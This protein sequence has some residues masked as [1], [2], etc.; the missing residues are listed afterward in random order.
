MPSDGPTPPRSSIR[1]IHAPSARRS[2]C[3]E[4]ALARN[5]RRRIGR[6]ARRCAQ[7][8]PRRARARPSTPRPR[9]RC[10]RF[11]TPHFEG[12][13]RTQFTRDLS[14]KD[15]VLHV[16]RG[17]RLVGFSTLPIFHTAFEGRQAQHRVTR[18]TP[19]CL[20]ARGVRLSL[21]RG[22]I[23]MVRR[24]QGALVGEPWY[25]LLLSSGFRTFRFLPVFWREFWP[26]HDA[27][28]PPTMTRLMA[29]LAR[30]RFGREFRKPPAWC[31][32]RR[33]SGSAASWPDRPRREAPRR[34]RGILS[35]AQPGPCRGRPT[36]LSGRV[37]DEN[38]TAAGAAWCGAAR[39][40]VRHDRHFR[41]RE[42]LLAG[43]GVQREPPLLPRARH[44]R[45]DAKR[46]GCGPNSRDTHEAGTARPTSS[47]RSTMA[48]HSR[49]ACRSSTTRHSHRGSRVSDAR[50]QG[51]R[52]RRRDAPQHADE[53]FDMSARRLIPFTRGLT[54]AF[55]AAVSPG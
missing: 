10:S 14:G 29:Q 17:D 8:R 45:R 21:A 36:G 1:G 53:R 2:R 47:L 3:Y 46:R 18:A 52:H 44:A 54:A 35:R 5:D 23:S 11:L 37:G 39:P 12:V 20:P 4:P 19:S 34:A 31:A 26:R 38:F 13:N 48:R 51:A 30:E 15:W 50:N 25:W 16:L 27:P 41:A 33:R 43:V 42:C 24:A 7:S 6:D 32:S 49:G 55:D 40:Q 9:T 28:T 22:W